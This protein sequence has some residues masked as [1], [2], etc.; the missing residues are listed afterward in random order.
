[1]VNQIATTTSIAAVSSIYGSASQVK[2]TVT[3]S[4]SNV[5]TGNVTLSLGAD[6]T[7]TQS[8]SAGTATFSVSGLQVG[9]YNLSASYASQGNFCGEH[10]QLY[11]SSDCFT[12]EVVHQ[13]TCDHCRKQRRSDGACDLLSGER[14]PVSYRCPL[15]TQPLSHR[16]S[17]PDRLRL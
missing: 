12:Y 5:P 2:V 14:H 13:R 16:L 11:P 8:L 1:M 10:G 15:G 17:P 7:L 3:G 6:S 4:P 9:N